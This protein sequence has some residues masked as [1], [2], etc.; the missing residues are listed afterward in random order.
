MLLRLTDDEAVEVVFPLSAYTRLERIRALKK[1]NPLPTEAARHAFDELDLMMKGL[2]QIRNN[3]V[4]A[5]LK[6]DA[7]ADQ[8][9]ELRSRRRFFTKAEIF[10]TEELTNYTAHAA[11]VLREELGAKDS[12]GAPDPLPSRPPIPEFLQKLVPA[13]RAMTEAG[14]GRKRAP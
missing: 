3:V 7:K 11:L 9:F 1:L 2:R 13:R 6:E 14:R 5:V 8:A 4:H 12:A 10:A